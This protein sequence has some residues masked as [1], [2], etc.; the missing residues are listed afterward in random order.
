MAVCVSSR[1]VVAGL[2]QWV[3]GR[4]EELTGRVFFLESSGHLPAV[5]RLASADDVVFVP[6]GSQE[7]D[8]PAMTARYSGQFVGPGDEMLIEGR[9]AVELQ[10]YLAVAFLPVLGLTVVRLENEA[11]WESFLA[12][13]DLA[14]GGGVFVEQLMHPAVLLADTGVTG[15]SHAA[16]TVLPRAH[17]TVEGEIRTSATGTTVGTVDSTLE[18]ILQA[19]G[20]LPAAAET[21]LCGVVAPEKVRGA[22]CQ[23]P[24][25]PRYLNALTA[26][27]SV[28]RHGA[29]WWVS[30]FGK[31]LV[32]GVP[33]EAQE[34]TTAPL[35]LWN[36]EDFLL[37]DLATNRR[38]GLGAD[39]A[40]LAELLI[41]ADSMGQ[42]VTRAVE[43]LGL[44]E[45]VAQQALSQLEEKFRGAGLNGWVA[46][47]AAEAMR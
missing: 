19:A 39:A 30:G 9:Y 5:L 41:T 15:F 26:L 1:S 14:R 2:A 6:E 29:N 32:P 22:V 28:R 10:D 43:L 27:R 45:P 42:A 38:F 16:S 31:R 35:L 11:D 13:A 12:D 37:L 20:R 8:G 24:W 44:P 3:N 23:R 36:D 33:S 47:S 7:I 25:L 17:V 21:D 4:R 46:V 34:L 40:R 18:E